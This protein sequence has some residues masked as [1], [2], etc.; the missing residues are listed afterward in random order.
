MNMTS[1][2]LQFNFVCFY[3]CGHLEEISENTKQQ[4][5]KFPTKNYGELATSSSEGM[6]NGLRKTNVFSIFYSKSR[7][8]TVT[9]SNH[10]HLLLTD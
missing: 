2:L 4:F 3:L 6:K 9:A 7:F 1:V 5:Q 10:V 8:I